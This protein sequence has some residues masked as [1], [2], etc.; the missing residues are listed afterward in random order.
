VGT[1]VV[2]LSISVPAIPERLTPLAHDVVG[3]P[4]RPPF[5]TRLR[6]LA[7]RVQKGAH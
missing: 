6:V 5:C 2:P 4:R 7:F 1:M 3:S